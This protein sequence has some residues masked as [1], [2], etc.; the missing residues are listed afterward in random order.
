MAS[1]LH[2]RHEIPENEALRALE[3]PPVDSNPETEALFAAELAKL[4]IHE[5]EAMLSDLHGVAD[6]QEE[7]AEFVARSLSDLDEAL[8]LI[9]VLDKHAY[10]LAKDLDPKYVNDDEFRLMFLRASSFDVKSAAEHMAN[11]FEAKLDLFGPHKLAKEITCDD[12]DEDDL[13][14]L[15]S[16]Y[17][18]V[19]SGRDRAGRA[20][21]CLMPMI[22][23]YKTLQN[24]VRACSVAEDWC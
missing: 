8:M 6:L 24:R 5:R 7:D 20:I 1:Y 21:L 17:A 12:L 2:P 11:F 14:C 23:E 10:E 4:S 22:R 15:E 19:L 3:P 13:K 9:P 16:G 18:Q